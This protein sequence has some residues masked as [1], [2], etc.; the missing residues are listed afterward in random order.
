M[1][2]MRSA[3]SAQ[4]MI[5]IPDV[6]GW[7]SGKAGPGWLV[8][9][10]MPGGSLNEDLASLAIPD[11]QKILDQISKVFKVIQSYKLPSAIQGYGG[12]N[13]DEHGN[14]VV[15]PTA[16]PCGGP[17]SSLTDMYKQLLRKQIDLAQDCKLISGWKSSNLRTRL[18][19][20][21]TQGVA[22]VLETVTDKTPCLVHADMSRWPTLD[23]QL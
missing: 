5:I 20:F 21:Y 10:H 13:F 17:F 22:K 1:V 11:Q 9:Q 12:L 19:L 3:L 18:E 2:L 7:S 6:H 23:I 16:I 8:E 4:G 14:V 15:G